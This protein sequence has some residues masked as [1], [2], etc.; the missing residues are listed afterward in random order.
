[1]LK[2]ETTVPVG[3]EAV[4]QVVSDLR[5]W[6]Q[7]LPTMDLVRQLDDGPIGVG[8]RFEVKQPGSASAAYTVTEWRENAGFTWE[9]TAPGVRTVATHTIT[10]AAERTVL[11]LGIQWHGPMSWLVRRL[12]GRRTERMIRLEADTFATRAQAE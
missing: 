3:S 4:W 12:Y 1:M 8:S 11:E 7:F 10:P 9:A 5:H 6:D 2:V